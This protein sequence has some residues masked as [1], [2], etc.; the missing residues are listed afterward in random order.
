M[1]IF[2]AGRVALFAV[3]VALTAVVG[4]VS[5][6]G[7]APLPTVVLVHGAFAD[8]SSWD[9]VAER[10]RGQGYRVVTPENPL[11]GPA[12][13]ARAIQS[14]LDTV[15]GPIVLA[16]H[17]YGGFVISN[18]HDPDVVS[19]VYVAAFAPVQGEVAQLAL[20]PI[21]FPGS[22]LLPPTLQ[23]ELVD[24]PQG[25][26]GRNLDGYVAPARFHDVF[27]QDV[28]DATAA[29]MLAHQ[30]S[31]AVAANLEPSGPPSWAEVPSWY[32]VSGQDRVIPA[33]S[34]RF[35]AGR[36]GARTSELDASHASLVSRPGEV[37][38]VITTA[39]G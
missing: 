38:A 25:P 34:Q 24:D 7:A 22:E 12:Y 32:V 36:M 3:F 29:N 11:R 5:P 18:V 13:D 39:A 35:M 16:G 20:D 30:R 31:I 27:A 14:V 19:M 21:R 4:G 1:T 15:E 8:S 28:D 33:S 17:S 26:M 10:L 37:A 9:G 6:A 2:R 23:V